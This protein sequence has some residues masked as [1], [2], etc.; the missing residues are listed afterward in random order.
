VL[1]AAVCLY[2]WA[3]GLVYW[4]NLWAGYAYTWPLLTLIVVAAVATTHAKKDWALPAAFLVGTL[5]VQTD[6]SMAVPVVAIGA[7]A[8]ALRLR[9]HPLTRPSRPAIALLVVTAAAWVPPIVEQLT[10]TKGNLGLLLSFATHSSGGHPLRA[11]LASTG[12]ALSVVPLGARWVLGSGLQDHLGAGPWWAVAWTL[13]FV[14]G[15]AA[16]AANAGRKARPLG[17][18]LALLT[19]VATL[20]AI[21]AM[22][23]VEGPIS[24]YLLMWV[25]ILPVPALTAAA[26]TFAPESPR[27]GYASLA[28][29]GL[30]AATVVVTRG[31]THDWD[32]RSSADVGALTARVDETVG[33]AARGLVGIHVVTA[34]TWPV[35][36]G[37]ALQLERQGARVQVDP[38]WVFLFGDGFKAG[39]TRPTAE[40]WFARPHERPGLS[41]KAGLVELGAV[42]GVD[43]LALSR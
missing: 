33:R 9:R 30:L 37:V 43:I 34:D 4:T 28:V 42:D 29:A 6:V 3:T 16:I 39:R 2:L 41:D 38:D 15:N 18:D 17:R 25:T 24:I 26:L 5:L 1:A 19:A 12:A 35:A 36:A 31:T 32:K 14:A 11:V 13:A 27:V 8:I 20:A 10:A 21:L 7:A 22:S 40:L 23:R